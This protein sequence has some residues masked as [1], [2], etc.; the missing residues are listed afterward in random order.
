MN[1]RIRKLPGFTLLRRTLRGYF[2]LRRKIRVPLYWWWCTS[3]RVKLKHGWHLSGRPLFR[4]RGS[5]ARITIGNHFSALSKSRF[6]AIGVFQP[7]IITAWGNNAVVEIADHVG[8]S[9][10]SITACERITIG[11]HVI[12]GSGCL[13]IDTDAHPL[14]PEARLRR[15]KPIS[16]AIHIE[17]D[18]FIGA[19]AIIL[20]GVRVGKGAVIGAGAV[21]S[22]D[23]P[24]RT[25]VAGNPAKPLGEV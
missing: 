20:K 7:V 9:G 18:V 14:S 11:N 24:A 8:I 5:G 15:D 21:V 12:I 4:M 25:I 2:R 1:E 23:V 22:H 16:K 10:S 19:R 13:I 6:N 17:D 3:Q